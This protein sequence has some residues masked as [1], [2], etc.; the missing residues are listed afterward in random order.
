MPGISTS[1]MIR[2]TSSPAASISAIAPAPREYKLKEAKQLAIVPNVYCDSGSENLNKDVDSLIENNVMRR[3]IAQIEVVQSNSMIEAFFRRLKHAWLFVHPLP[4]L[5]AVTHLT[6][7]YIHDH[8]Q[9]I[10]H[11]ALAGATPAEAFHG[12]W[13]QNDREK[14]EDGGRAARIARMQENRDAGCQRCALPAQAI[15]AP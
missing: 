11:A 9:L 2:E 13:S 6:E 3:T 8:N 5:A 4:S 7:Q 10:P 14:L 1:V 15:A 12:R